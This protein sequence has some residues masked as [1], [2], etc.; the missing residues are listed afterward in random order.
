MTKQD[1][2]GNPLGTIHLFII[3][4]VI[5]GM[6]MSFSEIPGFPIL[7]ISSK[8]FVFTKKLESAPTRALY[9]SSAWN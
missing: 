8:F 6:R 9:L 4:V 5:E 3:G 1:L 7:R 2:K